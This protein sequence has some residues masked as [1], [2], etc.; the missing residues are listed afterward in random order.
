MDGNWIDKS[1]KALE[2][3]V[4][5]S[6]E[7]STSIN[8]IHDS[9]AMLQTNKSHSDT[10]RERQGEEDSFVEAP[11]SDLNGSCN[12]RPDGLVDQMSSTPSLIDN[13]SMVGESD[14]P[15]TPLANLRRVN[16]S[17]SSSLVEVSSKDPSLS[18]LPRVRKG[19]H[20]CFFYQIKHCFPDLKIQKMN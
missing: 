2:T 12:A 15:S 13:Q 10:L 5:R 17:Q 11:E 6:K 9:D 19:Q 20:S 16:F 3:E 7:E 4:E 18:P 14:L 8:E 1:T